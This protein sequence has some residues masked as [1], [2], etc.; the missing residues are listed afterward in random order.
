MILVPELVTRCRCTSGR[1]LKCELAA[2]P[3]PPADVRRATSREIKQRGLR[4]RSDVY[5]TNTNSLIE[6]YINSYDL[7][8]HDRPDTTRLYVCRTNLVFMHPIGK[9]KVTRVSRT[10]QC[11]PYPTTLIRDRSECNVT[12]R[13]T[14]SKMHGVHGNARSTTPPPRGVGDLANGRLLADVKHTI[15]NAKLQL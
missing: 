10:V 12:V 15:S 9:S 8:Q 1:R 3:E 7:V 2:G 4:T 14:F 5:K 11:E 13:V 6:T